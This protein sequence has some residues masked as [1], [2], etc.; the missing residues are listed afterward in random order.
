M[1]MHRNGTVGVEPDFFLAEELW[2]G[3]KNGRGAKNDAPNWCVNG[4][5]ILPF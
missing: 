3:T 2:V 5:N 1:A 4:L